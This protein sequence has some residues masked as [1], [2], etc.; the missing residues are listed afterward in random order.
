M[1]NLLSTHFPWIFLGILLGV[2]ALSAG[3]ELRLAPRG[4]ILLSL[5]LRGS[6]FFLLFLILSDSGTAQWEKKR[7][8][9]P[10]ILLNDESD[11][12]TKMPDSARQEWKELSADLGR[13]LRRVPNLSVLEYRFSSRP[14]P[15]DSRETSGTGATAI[16]NTLAELQRKHPAAR[17][18]LFSDG[19]NNQGP[20]PVS[21]AAFLKN[22][23]AAVHVISGNPVPAE[24]MPDLLIADAKAPDFLH[25]EPSPRFTAGVFLSGL[26]ER[27]DITLET[28]L[29]IDGGKSEKKTVH[30]TSPA[31]AAE[32]NTPDPALLT[33]GWHEYEWKMILKIPGRPD[34]EKTVRDVF[35]VPQKNAVLLLWNRMEPELGTL[36]PVLR[37]RYR[38]LKFAYASRFA[39]RKETEQL[40]EINSL[41]LLLLGPVKPSELKK[42]VLEKLTER[43]KEK[44]L[45]LIF[46]DA[47]VLSDW[48]KVPGFAEIL[49][50]EALTRLRLNAETPFRFSA[51]ETRYEVPVKTLWRLTPRNRGIVRCSLKASGAE[52][53]MLISAGN[54][55]VIPILGAYRWMLAPERKH[56]LGYA[57]FWNTLLGS[58]DN[59]NRKEL[60]LSIEPEDPLFRENH[61]RFLVEDFAEQKKNRN[62]RL[63]RSNRRTGPME[64]LSAFDRPENRKA[65]LLLR[66]TEPG[67]WWFQA[68]DAANGEKTE[69]IPLVLR[70]DQRELLYSTPD[71]VA[72]RMT[73][74]Y[75]GGSVIG[76]EQIPAL[77]SVLEKQA[78]KRLVTLRRTAQDPPFRKHLIYGLA[79]VLLLIAEW[80]IRKWE[81]FHE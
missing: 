40:A 4:R 66:L 49:P 73:A 26:S 42:A 50:A 81:M 34:I 60:Q 79:A 2:L 3:I 39:A 68:E 77:V 16:G 51:G 44:S 52:L 9:L 55:S 45:N 6:A 61:Y 69:K 63:L 59:F 21:A 28:E 64:P 71:T 12:M 37:A 27:K 13:A 54:I 1:L 43:L 22:Q 14:V 24:E 38:G 19:R 65:F 29:S 58:A 48:E 5:A 78:A 62:L 20:H 47:S 74:L 25:A 76:R 7:E 10:V 15:A 80:G 72:L 53:P 30:V 8:P 11:S 32:Q 67:I 57:P 75:G 17:I 35:F 31:F 33:P 41:Q 46:L 36:L 70:A 18:L 23:G 56:A